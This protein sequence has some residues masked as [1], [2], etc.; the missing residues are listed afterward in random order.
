[1]S[2][3]TRSALPALDRFE[4]LL[5]ELEAEIGELVEQ[6]DQDS[7]APPPPSEEELE[8]APAS[9]SQAA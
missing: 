8:D 2:S 5:D 3:T 7:N 1:M 6:R 9:A 4:L